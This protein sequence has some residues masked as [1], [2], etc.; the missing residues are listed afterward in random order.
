MYNHIFSEI[1]MQITNL[2]PG[3]LGSNCYIISDS[4]HAAVID[5]SAT[6]SG[7]TKYLNDNSL[8]LDFIILT[9][10]HFD[11]ILS[12]DGLKE[13]TGV[14]AYVHSDDAEYLADGK[15]N[16]FAL[17]FGQ[18]RAF[19]PCERLLNHGDTIELGGIKLEIIHTPGHTK[20]CICIKAGDALFTGDTLFADAYGR[21][22]LYGGSY[23]ALRSSLKYLRQYSQG[24]DLTIY[25]GHGG[26]AKLK[27]ALDVVEYL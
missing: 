19:S 20:G 18:D 15:K 11:H 4:G 6:V 2:F 1:K 12:L 17:F 23:T 27:R 14:P 24:K 10:A 16:A 8:T 21:C 7:I 13:A 3:S 5:P 25:P 22:D 9:H 26:T